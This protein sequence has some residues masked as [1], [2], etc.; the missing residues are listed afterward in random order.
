MTTRGVDRV[1]QAVGDCD[2]FA[3]G[4]AGRLDDDRRATLLDIGD[5]RLEIGKTARLG[6]GDGLMPHELFGEPLVPFELGRPFRGAER[7][8][9]R[10]LQRIDHAAGQRVF[11]PD[12]DQPDL[13]LPAKIDQLAEVHRVDRD[14]LRDLRRPGIARQTKE[15][16]DPFRLR[17][18]PRKRVF[19]TTIS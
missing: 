4:K 17:Q 6:G 14:V 2:A 1:L 12:D 9:A 11:R 18:L 3:F 10:R 5:R 7:L 13:R 19:T 15:L 16:A 8:D